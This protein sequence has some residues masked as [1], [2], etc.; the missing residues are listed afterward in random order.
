MEQ[1]TCHAKR[2]PG[3]SVVGAP[4]H[5]QAQPHG[6]DADVLDA[7]VREETLDVVLGQGERDAQ[8]SAGRACG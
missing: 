8:D 7:V 4:E 1:A 6:Y 5:R 2:C 3:R